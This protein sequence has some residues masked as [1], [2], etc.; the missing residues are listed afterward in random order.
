MRRFS[1]AIYVP[2]QIGPRK[3]RTGEKCSEMKK[4]IEGLMTL[5]DRI[6]RYRTVSDGRYYV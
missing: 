6:L 3:I 5:S 1:R 4:R 2:I